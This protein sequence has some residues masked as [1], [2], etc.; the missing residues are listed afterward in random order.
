MINTERLYLSALIHWLT[1]GGTLACV[2]QSESHTATSRARRCINYRLGGGP[3]SVV[4]SST[5][6]TAVETVSGNEFNWPVAMQMKSMDPP[7]ERGARSAIDSYDNKPLANCIADQNAWD[8]VLTWA[9]RVASELDAKATSMPTTPGVMVICGSRLLMT[10]L[11]EYIAHKLDPQANTDALAAS[12]IHTGEF[13]HLKAIG[14]RKLG[15]SIVV[16]RWDEERM[17]G[18]TAA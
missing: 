6:A 1:Q 3:V 11:A 4:M 14:D 10:A 16:E 15:Y 17:L 2:V 9:G 18:R 7:Q 5:A 8:P 13:L 12:V